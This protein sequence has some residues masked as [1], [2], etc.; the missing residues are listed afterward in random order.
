MLLKTLEWL[1]MPH[2]AS[3]QYACQSPIKYLLSFS[4]SF[5]SLVQ[6]IVT[7]G[8]THFA[9]SRALRIKVGIWTI[10][11]YNSIF[12]FDKYCQSIHFVLFL[13]KNS[14]SIIFLFKNLILI[15]SS[16]LFTNSFKK[17]WL[18]TSNLKCEIYA[19]TFPKNIKTLV[20]ITFSFSWK[21]VKFV[22]N[23]RKMFYWT[24]LLKFIKKIHYQL[25][26]FYHE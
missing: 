19:K 21:T 5:W 24:K 6:S 26:E 23:Q 7:A 11:L 12:F 18:Q 14:I 8:W 25:R 10:A 15:K 4:R 16:L 17:Q 1:L 22:Q 2:S 13:I 9:N 20:F 3:V